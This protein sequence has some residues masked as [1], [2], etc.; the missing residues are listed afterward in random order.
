MAN[1]YWVGG[2]AAWDGTAGSKWSTSS[3]GG[4]GASVPTSADAVFFTNLST[5]TCTISTGNTGALSI[6]CTGFTGTLAGTAAI[7]VSGGVTLAAGMTFTYSGPLTIN[8]TGTITSAGKTFSPVTVSG[9]GI[10]VTL[11]DAFTQGSS[12]TRLFTLTQGTLALAGF[13]LTCGVFSSSGSST[14][15]ISF[16]AGGIT[17]THNSGS[18]T[19]LSMAN[20]TNFSWTGS[21]GNEGFSYIR[22]SSTG[23]GVF[24][25]GT[26]GGT[27]SNA[28]NI[29]LRSAGAPTGSTCAITSGSY[30]K[31]LS[32]PSSSP[33]FIIPSLGGIYNACGNLD[34]FETDVIGSSNISPTFLASGTLRT[35]FNTLGSVTVNG[36]G[37]TVTLIGALS[38]A[39]SS[40]FTLT[41]GTLALN[42]FNLSTPRFLSN[43]T[44][45][46][47]ISF[48]TG[49]IALTS[50]TA[51]TT[52]LDMGTATNF[53]MTTS[54]GG[55]TRNQAATATVTFGTTGGT[56]TNAPNLTVNAGAS[57]L[58]ITSGSYFK[59]VNFTGSTSVVLGGAGGGTV[60]IAGNVTLASGGTYT[61][62]G[63]SLN[64]S[65]TFTSNG[66]S[67]T[68][69]GVNG[70]GITVTLA[71]AMTIT[72]PSNNFTLTQ[73][74]LNLAGFT[75]T[76]PRFSSSNSNTRGINF[77]S[78]GGI[79]L[80]SNDSD[81]F[82]MDTATNFTWSGTGGITATGG[83]GVGR[84]IFGQFGGATSSNVLNLTI[85]TASGLVVEFTAGSSVKSINC[86]SGN[87]SLQNLSGTTNLYGNLT[88]IAGVG[89]SYA[90]FAPTFLSSA[91]I[92][93][94]GTQLGN[95]TIN[96][97]GITVTLADAMTLGP[98]NTLTLT[99]GT[100]TA[101][102]FNVTAGSFS[103]SNSNTRT[104]NMGSGTWTINDSGATAWNTAT[105]T[106]LTVV[107][108][109]STITMTSASAKTFA[110]GGLTYYNLNQGGAGAL[111]ITGSNAF[112][113]ITN[114]TQPATV[115]FTASTTQTL[116]AFGLSG[117]AGNLITV[118]SATP[119]SQF[120]LSKASGTVDAQ[121]LAI[122][123][124]N[125]TGGAIWNSL[126]TNG[127]VNNGNNTGWVFSLA[128]GNMFL[129]FN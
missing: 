44:N 118:N 108:S 85:A 76:T 116:S 129:M 117:T 119:G 15:A 13:N 8:G 122:Q 40:T 6:N 51:G 68:N 16:G 74:T 20:M 62:I 72:A 101:A 5:G 12:S 77:G 31:N 57:Q 128:G 113:N 63:F 17:L 102:N 27:V 114:S 105:T 26:T 66:K 103:S 109:T 121:Y 52:V 48:G 115:T 71:D 49:N 97:S 2:T 37:I 18:F 83:S 81:L 3:G 7:T 64:A 34:I 42:D 38:I 32:I 43:N 82:R 84:F 96:G 25:T 47:A 19:V 36:S 127:N 1:R 39:S 53:T 91:T 87:P 28:V 92:T 125:A 112:N 4:G 59:N 35:N 73:G 88:L 75:L 45:A 30:I 80:T 22:D 78:G 126:L 86:A 111:T 60:N 21:T 123:D 89:S 29:T 33:Q 94:A 55:F 11:G 100:F 70:S 110:G 69:S 67:I 23:T 54:G 24:T 98:A 120:T 41:Q 14:R 104:L 46:R 95:T 99:Q 50:T 90:A 106:G 10:T 107:P 65:G 124:S 56:T 58:S 93:S 79:T 9:A 61:S